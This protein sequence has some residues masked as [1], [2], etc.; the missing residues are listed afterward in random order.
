MRQGA[1]GKVTMG[2]EHVPAVIGDDGQQ[3]RHS[4]FAAKPAKRQVGRYEAFLGCVCDHP[5]VFQHPQAEVV[6]L[7]P[8]DLYEAIGE[9]GLVLYR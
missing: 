7:R 1:S 4:M 5:P 3:P 8:I 9:A 2:A 6:G